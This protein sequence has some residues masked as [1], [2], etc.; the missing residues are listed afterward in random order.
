MLSVGAKCNRFELR[1]ITKLGWISTTSFFERFMAPV[2]LRSIQIEDNGSDY[3]P[4]IGRFYW[5]I[6]ARRNNNART[7][8]IAATTVPWDNPE[9]RD[10]QRYGRI[11]VSW[12][13]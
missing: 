13:Y 6:T 10:T 1:R 12:T 8:S 2:R 9:D 5:G 7:Y 11:G 3:D 4:L